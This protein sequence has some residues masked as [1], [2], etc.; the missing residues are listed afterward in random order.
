MDTKYWSLGEEFEHNFAQ[1]QNLPPRHCFIKHKIQGGILPLE[2]ASI[3]PAWQ[4]LKM[5]PEEYVAYLSGLPFGQKYLL[6]RAA[7]T[8]LSTGQPELPQSQSV[9]LGKTPPPE[10]QEVKPQLEEQ[11]QA[12]LEFVMA[13]PETPTTKVYKELQVS[14]RRGI[15]LRDTLKAQGLIA[16]IE[17]RLGRAGRR[18]LF[19]IPTFTA[20]ELLGKEPSPGR[21]GTIHRHIQHL[22]EEGA[23][24]NGFTAKC[25]YD[26][27]NGGIVDVHL[28]KGDY[29]VAVEIA[30]ASRPSREI[31]HIKNAIVVGYDRVFD[32]FAEGKM[33]QKTQEALEGGFSAEDR[34]KIQLLHLSKLSELIYS[35]VSRD[36]GRVILPAEL[37][38]P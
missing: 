34:E 9:E 1:L 24:A 36:G 18:T 23:T 25:E 20:F 37:M 8:Q 22:I 11:E 12:F 6:E 7:L 15:D 38:D 16:E 32:V 17:T 30:V 4:A 5:T 14:V 10:P 28:E 29:R 35:I 3:E 19:F 26:L 2:T 13:N 27:G 31:A 21:G 33:L